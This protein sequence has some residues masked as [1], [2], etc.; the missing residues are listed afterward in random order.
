MKKFGIVSLISALG[1][2]SLCTAQDLWWISVSFCN[3]WESTKSLSIVSE[4]GT[5]SEICM[6]FANTTEQDVTINYWFVD[7]TV[8]ADI[9]KNKACLNEWDTEKFWQYVTQDSKELF[10]PAKQVVRQ[11]AHVKFPLWLSGMMNWC[12]TYYVKDNQWQSDWMFNVLV[13]KALFVDVLV[14]WEMK[15]DIKL[16]DSNSYSYTYDKESKSY[17][18]QIDFDNLW[19][20]DELISITWTIS[21][22]FWFSRDF[23]IDATKLISDGS[24]KIELDLWDLPWYKM[25]Y[26][27][28]AHVVWTPTFTFSS[29]LVP[30]ELKQPITIDLNLSIFVFP[31][32]LALC[33]VWLIILII[34]IKFLSKHLKFQ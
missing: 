29:D 19:N 13:R 1:L 8:T 12:L 24:E 31:W 34:L 6:D 17:K 21:N 22:S 23:T 18:M 28:T 7:G 14:W 30:D 4:V 9:Y 5:E 10:I 2:L 3:N 33:F 16:S 26:K 32:L 25:N 15:R 20:V 27:V 11:K